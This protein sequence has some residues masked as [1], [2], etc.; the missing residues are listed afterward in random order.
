[1]SEVE[2]NFEIGLNWLKNVGKFDVLTIGLQECLK[3]V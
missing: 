3:K 1:M 2:P